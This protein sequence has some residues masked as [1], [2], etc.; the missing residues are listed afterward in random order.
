MDDARGSR[1]YW[2]NAATKLHIPT[3]G[4]VGGRH[5]DPVG[6]NSFAAVNPANGKPLAAIGAYGADDVDLAV[7][8]ARRA[9]EQGDWSRCDPAERR[10]ILVRLADLI[11]AHQEELA[12]LET[13]NMGKL[14]QDSLKLDIPTAA[15]VFRWYGEAADKLVDEI[16]PAGDARLAMVTREAVGVVGAVVPWNF[17]LK[18]A[19]WK[20]APALAAGNSVLLKPA[21]Q[22]PLTALRL[23]ELAAE[24]GVPPGVF[25][26]L[27]GLGHEAGRAIGLHPDIDCVAFTG[28]TEVG[29]LFLAYA[30]Q[31]N[32]KRVW[33][34]CGGKSANIV[35]PAAKDL[36][37]AAKAAASGIYFN[38]GEVC[39]ATSRLYV[40]ASIHDEFLHLLQNELAAFQPGDPL[41]PKSGMGA[42]VSEEHLEKVVGY[43]DFG[44]DHARLVAGG[45]RTLSETGGYFVE[46]TIFADVQPE[47]I[48]S[49]E[50]IFGPV[51]SVARFDTEDAAVALANASIYGL[52]ASVWTNDLSQAHRVARRLQ[53]G[54]VSINLVDHVDVRTPFG[55]VKQSGTGRDLSLHAFDKYTELKTTWIGL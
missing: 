35:F 3:R 31:S 1:S 45:N 5:V 50:E 43:I 11:L 21:E 44:K 51:L 6:G 27:P 46:P 12:L 23:A 55:G 32:M 42:L 24:A 28:S 29:K 22:S 49:R 36:Q 26:V 30:S 40:H 10:K 47:S 4:F 2:H 8:S 38:Q 13:L 16:I 15:D 19:A 48:L 34:E 37:A 9:F 53:A 18:M 33:L 17:P 54:T 7:Q 52:G 41:D 20:C 14:I 39:S 25:N